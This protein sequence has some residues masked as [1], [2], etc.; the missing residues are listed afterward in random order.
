MSNTPAGRRKGGQPGN[1]NRLRH[2]LYSKRLSSVGSTAPGYDL[3]IALYRRRLARLLARQEGASLR[4][5]LSYERGI[6]HCISMILDLKRSSALFADL[7]PTDLASA[8]GHPF[9]E[10]LERVPLHGSRSDL[11]RPSADPIRTSSDSIPIPADFLL[12]SFIRTSNCS[13]S[14]SRFAPRSGSENE[15]DE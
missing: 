11:P 8:D 7:L 4:D 13:S 6:L 10:L 15:F 14:Q 2:G 9:A 12:R 3:Q 5:Y 1:T